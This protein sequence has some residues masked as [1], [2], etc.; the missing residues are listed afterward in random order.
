MDTMNE[1]RTLAVKVAEKAL[2]DFP[3]GVAPDLWENI[4]PDTKAWEKLKKLSMPSDGDEVG[5]AN[6]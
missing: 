1:A 2:H 5:R 3:A 6:A 4:E